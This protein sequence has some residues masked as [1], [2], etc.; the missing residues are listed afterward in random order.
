MQLDVLQLST[1]TQQPTTMPQRS[2]KNAGKSAGGRSGKSAGGRSGKSAGKSAGGGRS[3][4]SAGKHA[5]GGR[6]GKSAG[7]PSSEIKQCPC[8][9]G[10]FC[11]YLQCEYV[12]PEGQLVKQMGEDPGY[13]DRICTECYEGFEQGYSNDCRVHR[14]NWKCKICFK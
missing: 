4:K 3:G 2:G 1:L 12:H 5:G 8:W 10:K 13:I 6:S 9:N 7:K 14:C 11:V